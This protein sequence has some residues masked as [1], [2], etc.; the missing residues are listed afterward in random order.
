QADLRRPPLGAL[1]RP[2]LDNDFAA[3]RRVL[4]ERAAHAGRF[5]EDGSSTGS[6]LGA[7]GARHPV[8]NLAAAATDAVLERL[9]I[10]TAADALAFFR[11]HPAADFRWL[12]VSAR[13]PAPP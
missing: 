11:R 7:D 1:A 12:K 13:F 3:L 5:V 2:P 10:E 8:P 4:E 6:Y 9:G